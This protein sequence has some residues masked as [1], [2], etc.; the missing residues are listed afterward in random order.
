MTTKEK[1]RELVNE[2][3]RLFVPISLGLNRKHYAK[4]CALITVDESIK[5]YFD[6]EEE[7]YEDFYRSEISY[8]NELK[9]EIENI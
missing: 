7:M 1:A 4:K 3:S 9:Q 2:F 5:R 6:L 8:L